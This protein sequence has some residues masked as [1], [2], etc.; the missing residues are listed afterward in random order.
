MT[1]FQIDQPY[2]LFTDNSGKPLDNGSIYIG[3]EGKDPTAYP[4]PIYW[5][6]DLTIPASQP[7]S[8]LNGYIVRNGAP[9]RIFC[10]GNFSIIIKDKHDNLVTYTSKGYA[11]INAVSTTDY[12][13]VRKL[14]DTEIENG[15]QVS[16][17]F[18]DLRQ[19][20]K[21]VGIIYGSVADMKAATG[22]QI[23]DYIQTQNY[24]STQP[25]GGEY[26]EIVAAGT[27]TD[28]GGSYIDLTGSGL[29]AKLLITK[30][31]ID[32]RS[33]GAYGDGI[34]DDVTPC[35][36]AI[37]F[38][39]SKF[40]RTKAPAGTYYFSNPGVTLVSNTHIFGDINT[41]FKCERTYYDDS[42][43]GT[44]KYVIGQGNIFNG[45]NL[46]NITFENITLVGSYETSWGNQI[47]GG[48]V[49]AGQGSKLLFLLDCENITLDKFKIKNSWSSFITLTTTW[50]NYFEDIYGY[51]QILISGCTNV[52]L[53]DCMGYD[54]VGEAWHIFNSNNVKVHNS[55]W[56]NNYGVS[57]LDITYCTNVKV[58]NSTFRKLLAADTG[59]LC[60][61]ASSEVNITGC[62]FLNGE[63]DVGNEYIVVNITLGQNFLLKN[64]VVTNNT[65]YNGN[66]T[67]A[68]PDGTTSL[69]WVQENAIIENNSFIIDLD[70]RPS[71][72]GTFIAEYIAVRLPA[73]KNNRNISVINNNI[74]LKGALQSGGASYNKIRIF[75]GNMLASGYT[76]EN[77]IIEGN[78]IKVD[79]TGYDPADINT[80]SG[81]LYTNWGNWKNL[82]FNNNISNCPVG[83]MI[84]QHE[85]LDN[86][87][88][89]R[90][91]LESEGFLVMP[92]TATDFDIS[93]LSIKDNK[94]KFNNTSGYTY[95]SANLNAQGWGYFINILVGANTLVEEF[96]I[97]NNKIESPGLIIA[98]NFSSS[99]SVVFDMLIEKNKVTFIDFLS[100]DGGA[101]LYPF[102]IGR[103]NT[104]NDYS[105]FKINENYFKN[106]SVLT[107]SFVA[108]EWDELDFL[109]NEYIGDYS[110]SFTCD[111]LAGVPS[112]RFIGVDNIATDTITPTWTNVNSCVTKRIARNTT[113]FGI[114]A[115]I[116]NNL[117]TDV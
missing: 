28:D 14:T 21:Y 30:N 18:I 116:T 96:D 47:A 117:A 90:N 68:T 106:E 101:T 34:A 8:T 92:Y 66:V 53:K 102:N 48:P 22:L 94:F 60:N 57:Y 64:T 12:G 50:D 87:E 29:Q 25:G 84:D 103:T 7:L 20:K 6:E 74:I 72:T 61:V 9:S 65:F 23:G 79:L 19:I 78:T 110:I 33:F 82:K 114:A 13:L 105:K 86:I 43:T 1:A 75:S 85:S 112:S 24:Y 71:L 99:T 73:A 97:V 5:D 59:N 10:D 76:M 107:V 27:G 49:P 81:L 16:D 115:A 52:N 2:P 38:A 42:G 26:Y 37:I 63:L 109:R 51:H 58:K 98:T 41:F 32:M 70:T 62:Y 17:A 45:D 100:L 11:L 89:E 55:H 80:D 83:M 69:T 46:E 44:S 88:I 31:F 108:L 35:E 54:S 77:I 67:F 56:V 113:S 111:N 4:I 15:I 36:N 93:R 104:S 95:T 40:L 91:N 39:A 3:E